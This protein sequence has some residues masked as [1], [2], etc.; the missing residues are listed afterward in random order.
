M[1]GNGDLNGLRKLYRD[2]EASYDLGDTDIRGFSATRLAT[3]LDNLISSGK[4]TDGEI[5]LH[6]IHTWKSDAFESAIEASAANNKKLAKSF[7]E[8]A[9][10][11]NLILET[12]TESI[13]RNVD[14][15][16][17]IS[18]QNIAGR[19]LS[20]DDIVDSILTYRKAD[21]E[22]FENYVVPFKQGIGGKI[23]KT[24]S[25][26]DFVIAPENIF[27]QFI[28]ANGHIRARK[29]YNEIFKNATEKE[30]ETGKNLLM[31]NVRKNVINNEHIPDD[32]LDNFEDLLGQDNVSKVRRIQDGYD[33]H[34]SSIVRKQSEG[35]LTRDL[36]EIEAGLGPDIDALNNLR[37]NIVDE[38]PTKIFEII[39]NYEPKNLTKL[40]D[41]LTETRFKRKGNDMSKEEIMNEVKQDLLGVSFDGIKQQII[42]LQDGIGGLTS[43]SDEGFKKFLQRSENLDAD[44]VTENYFRYLEE[45]DGK[46]SQTL[47]AD[48]KRMFETLGGSEHV[49]RLESVLG[50][51]KVR[52]AVEKYVGEVGGVPAVVGE[53]YFFGRSYNAVKG[54][55]SYRYLITEAVLKTIRKKRVDLI[56]EMVTNPNAASSIIQGLYSPN[57]SNRNLKATAK[58]LRM[59]YALPEDT[60]DDEIKDGIKELPP[61]FLKIPFLNIIPDDEQT[62]ELEQISNIINPQ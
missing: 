14:T 55:L 42:K 53:A 41:G 8:T 47:I 9:N 43:T 30:I 18:N 23:I 58:W 52:S 44:D 57:P 6:A 19:V 21:K 20:R 12:A 4:T 10:D 1:E 48:T 26:G 59:M 25:S 11:L 28:K 16:P 51:T 27:Q 40:I 62:P 34:Y 39:K 29:N 38:D 17:N 7:F 60:T 31:E 5:S 33:L 2:L 61:T 22:Y 54:H 56:A 35:K 50:Q 32:F 15:T 13:L 37:K 46:V 36:K 24:D 45:L 3:E 49:R